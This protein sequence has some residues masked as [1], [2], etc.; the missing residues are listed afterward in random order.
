METAV[1]TPTILNLPVALATATNQLQVV[2]NVS[3]DRAEIET[4][5]RQIDVH[6]VNSIISF[7]VE[8]QKG[9]T[10]QADAILNG[11]KNKDTGPAGEVMNNLMVVIRGLG[12]EDLDPNNRPG[13]F[14]RL[15]SKLTPIQKFVQQYEGIQSQVDT[16]V[17]RLESEKRTLSRDIIMLDG[18]YD[19]ALDYFHKLRLYI[20]AAELRLN[21]VNEVDMPEAKA[22]AE[23]GEMLEAQQ[24][25]DLQERTLDLERKLNDLMLT[26]TA[27]MQMLPQLRMIQDVD[28]GLCTKIQSQI[29]TTVPIWKQQIAM[30]ITL[31]RQAEAVKVTKV[32]SDATSDMLEKN[33]KLLRMNSADARKEMERGVVDIESLKKA[34]ADLI[35]S[36]QEATQIAAEGRKARIAAQADMVKLESDLKVALKEAA[37]F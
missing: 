36:I 14:R 31:W 18:M 21:Q 12:I 2:D 13:F 20:A 30:A 35:A 23:A 3:A 10:G 16:M 4:L 37:N 19:E 7:G 17:D 11:V 5:A 15:L 33:A 34:N 26:R 24:L 6:D 25:R 32:V 8:A 28:K 29:D 27:T 9:L 22:K 1:A